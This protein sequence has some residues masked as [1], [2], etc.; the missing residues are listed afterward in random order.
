M[1]P[2]KSEKRQGDIGADVV[3]ALLNAAGGDVA[4]TADALGAVEICAGLW[5]RAFASAQVQPAGA[6]TDALTA[7]LLGSIGR[8][9]AIRGE[10]V[11]LIDV[12]RDGLKLTPAAAWDIT[13]SASPETWMYELKLE[14][15]SGTTTRVVPG[16]Q[17]IHPRYAVRPGKPWK[18]LSPLGA[19]TKTEQ[20]AAWLETSLGNEVATAHGYILALPENH[21]SG[22]LAATMKG[23]KGRLFL[24]D[25]MAGAWGAGG[26]YAP[27]KDWTTT[28]LG[29]SPPQA[30]GELR[31]GAQATVMAAYGVPLGM[32]ESEAASSLREQWRLFIYA[33]IGPLGKTLAVE[34]A[35]KLDTPALAFNFDALAASDIQ[36]RSRSFKQLVDAGMSIEDAGRVTGVGASR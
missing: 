4:P 19:A 2:F 25:T 16:A 34:L 3:N 18:G 12:D 35:D 11:Y 8:E 36:G 32:V 14:G 1:W 6:A 27:P 28:R 33:T 15:P 13:G 24:G 20:L 31:T 30:L 21:K 10:A 23:L 22:G 17:V 29:A 7:S 9:L 26:Q 5:S